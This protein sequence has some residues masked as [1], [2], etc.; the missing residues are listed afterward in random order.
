M[1]INPITDLQNQTATNATQRTPSGTLGKDDFLRLM[2]G[3]LQNQDPMN[4]TDDSQF[5]AQIAQM[6][7]LEQMTNM[8]TSMQQQQA[9]GMLG[10]TVTY[11]DPATGAIAMGTVDKI[12][13]DG[14]KV[15]LRIGD[16]DVAPEHVT[17]VLN[18]PADESTTETTPPT[19]GSDTEPEP[20]TPP[21]S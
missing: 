15:N 10:K 3:K 6:T 9:F 17:S 14:S 4:P 7:S 18:G 13:I 21:T 2:V 20:E 5:M 19:G 1:P 12:V 8:A 11:T 16:V